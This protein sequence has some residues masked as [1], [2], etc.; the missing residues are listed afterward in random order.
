MLTYIAYAVSSRIE[1][2]RYPVWDGVCFEFGHIV[3]KY[4]IKAYSKV[5]DDGTLAEF[6]IS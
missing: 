1:Y 5:V 4:L 6:I 2:T 3:L